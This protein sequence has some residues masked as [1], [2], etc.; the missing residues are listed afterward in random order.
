MGL[1]IKRNI[2]FQN[3]DE[4]GC[5]LQ[6]VHEG[7]RQVNYLESMSRTR[8][9]AHMHKNTREAFYIISGSVVVKFWNSE[10]K[11]S[12]TFKKGDFFEIPTYVFHDMYFPEQ[13]NM[14]QMYEF[15]VVDDNGKKDIFREDQT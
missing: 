1:Y 6:L 11:Q 8:R 10:M 9:G 12:E 2:E 13:C 14:I 4:R 3:I 15:P 7:F 5:L